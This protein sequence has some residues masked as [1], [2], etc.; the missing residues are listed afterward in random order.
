M[1]IDKHS[2]TWKFIKDEIDAELKT[3][4][5]KTEKRGVAERD[6]DFYRG[7]IALG[8]RLLRLAEPQ[9]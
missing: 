3:A 4:R 8:K 9:N 2:P 5:A 6:A 7:E 1:Q